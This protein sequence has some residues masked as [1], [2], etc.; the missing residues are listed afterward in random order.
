MRSYKWDRDHNC[1][2]IIKFALVTDWEQGGGQ[3]TAKKPVPA[4]STHS[5][6]GCC[7]CSLLIWGRFLFVCLFPPLSL[8]HQRKQRLGNSIWHDPPRLSSVQCV[9]CKFIQYLSL[10]GVE[11]LR[12]AAEL[13]SK[14]LAGKHWTC[15]MTHCGLYILGRVLIK[16]QPFSRGRGRAFQQVAVTAENFVVVLWL[17]YFGPLVR[18]GKSA[19]RQHSRRPESVTWLHFSHAAQITKLAAFL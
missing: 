12:I 19:D 16:K 10:Q 1:L 6:T 8:F 15:C 11:R 2:D 13:D 5:T 17:H 7:I 3:R 18:K 9:I 4:F 14:L